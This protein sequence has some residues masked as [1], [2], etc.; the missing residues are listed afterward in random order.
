[1][2]IR[3]VDVIKGGEHL[4]ALLLLCWLL[5]YHR[6]RQLQRALDHIQFGT[7][8]VVWSN[9]SRFLELKVSEL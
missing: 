3:I 7:Q 1:M 4:V 5:I 8:F 6:I 2:Q 9:R